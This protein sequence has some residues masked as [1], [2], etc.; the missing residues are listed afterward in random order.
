LV[1]AG[2]L[3]L[4]GAGVV[5]NLRRPDVAFGGA[6]P[7]IVAL[8]VAGGVAVILDLGFA[9]PHVRPLIQWLD[10]TVPPYRGMR[11]AGKWAALIALAY[12]QLVPIGAVA[13]VSWLRRD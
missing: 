2:L 4:A 8:L 3:V 1:L 9:E 5:A 13:L 10:T 12:A 7:W 6:R 11:D